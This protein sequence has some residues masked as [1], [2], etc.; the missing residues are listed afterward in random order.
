MICENKPLELAALEVFEM[1]LPDCRVQHHLPIRWMVGG[2][3]TD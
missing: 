1:D 2:S 3:R